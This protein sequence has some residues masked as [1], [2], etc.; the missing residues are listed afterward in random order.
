MN[1]KLG[2]IVNSQEYYFQK[3]EDAFKKFDD[4]KISNNQI[5]ILIDKVSK[6]YDNNK[7]KNNKFLEFIEENKE[8]KEVFNLIGQI[9]SKTKMIKKLLKIN[10]KLLMKIIKNLKII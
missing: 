8:F 7:S 2:L 1:E 6:F 5:D 9:I 10:T 3:L 4:Y